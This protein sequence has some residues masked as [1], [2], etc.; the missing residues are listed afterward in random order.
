MSAKAPTI[1][2]PGSSRTYHL[3]GIPCLSI[4]TQKIS[5][6]LMFFRGRWKCGSHAS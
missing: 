5:E 1:A 6:T 2:R 4:F 3:S